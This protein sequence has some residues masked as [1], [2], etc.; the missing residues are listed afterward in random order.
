MR[1]VKLYLSSEVGGA[2]HTAARRLS[3]SLSLTD[4]FR[5][6]IISRVLNTGW[7]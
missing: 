1:A 7:E 3:L 2:R 5:R 4:R 6:E